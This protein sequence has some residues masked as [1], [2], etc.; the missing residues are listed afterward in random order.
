M[1]AGAHQ[2]LHH[3]ASH[4]AQSDHSQFHAA[5]LLMQFAGRGCEQA[6]GESITN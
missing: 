4:T 6:F 2:A 1:V 3:V 5:F